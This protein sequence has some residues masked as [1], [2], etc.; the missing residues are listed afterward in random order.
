[1][2]NHRWDEGSAIVEGAVALTLMIP[3]ILGII[4]FGIVFYSANTMHLVIEELGRYAM[5]NNTANVTA[6]PGTPPTGC[7]PIAQCVATKATQLLKSYPV[8]LSPAVSVSGCT[9]A[10]LSPEAPPMMTIQGTF[11]PL[12]L[13]LPIPALTT[14]ITVPLS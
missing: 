3:I 6:C 1:M 9:A 13:L 4:E 5:V 12:G 14:Q 11:T 7:P 2:K 8:L 10:T